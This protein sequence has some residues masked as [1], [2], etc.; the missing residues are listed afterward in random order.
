MGVE[1]MP[2]GPSLP[3][4]FQEHIGNVLFSRCRCRWGTLSGSSFS[5]VLTTEFSHSFSPHWAVNQ[6]LTFCRDLGNQRARGFMRTIYSPIAIAVSIRFDWLTCERVYLIWGSGVKHS[7]RV[8]EGAILLAAVQAMQ[9][10]VD[11]CRV[12]LSLS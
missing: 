8:S 11:E 2:F 1:C 6:A 10:G 12:L 4:S 9:G 7:T 5:C 3:F